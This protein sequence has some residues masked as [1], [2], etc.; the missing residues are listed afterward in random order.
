VMTAIGTLG[1][2]FSDA[3]AIN[4]RGQI[5]G[6][7]TNA[8]GNLRAFLLD[9]GRMRDLGTLGGPNSAARDINERGAVVGFSSAANGEPHA[10]VW[11]R[12]VMVDLNTVLRNPSPGFTLMEANAINDRGEI[13]GCA[14]VGG[15]ERAFLLKPAHGW[16]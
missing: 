8:E 6:A 13:T 11:L 5:V 4:D 10:F 3:A 9:D 2:N 1:G 16:P 15:A 14:L 7:S 12:G